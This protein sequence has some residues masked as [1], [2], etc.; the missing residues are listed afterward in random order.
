MFCVSCFI[1]RFDRQFQ[2]NSDGG[3]SIVHTFDI[4]HELSNFHSLATSIFMIFSQSKK[5]PCCGA[6]VVGLIQFQLPRFLRRKVPRMTARSR[7]KSPNV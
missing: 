3:L 1:E 6:F 7:R 4:H 2:F 5:A